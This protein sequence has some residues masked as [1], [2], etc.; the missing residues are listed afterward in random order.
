MKKRFE[1]LDDLI[2]EPKYVVLFTFISLLAV[3][4]I[5][6][7]IA[8]PMIRN[9]VTKSLYDNALKYNKE[10]SERIAKLLSVSIRNGESPESVL[11]RFQYMLL[12]SPQTRSQYI[13]IVDDNDTIIAHPKLKYIGLE[14]PNWRMNNSQGEVSFSTSAREGVSIG[15]TLTKDRGPQ[16]VVF[17]APVFSL[18]WS[19][20]VHSSIELIRMDTDRILRSFGLITIPTLFFIILI[21]TFVARRISTRSEEKLIFSIEALNQQ[22]KLTNLLRMTAANANRTPD[23]TEAVENCLKII[24]EHMCWP[25]GHVYLRSIENDNLL[26]P[27]NIWYLKSKKTHT[28]FVHITMKSELGIGID[29]PGKV[30]KNCEKIWLSD[31]NVISDL[32]R[33]QQL[34]DV[35]YNEAFA[36]PVLVGD[37]CIAVLEFFNDGSN[38]I[39]NSLLEISTNI[40]AQL[41]LV[42]ERKEAE[43]ELRKLM[44]EVDAINKDLEIKVKHRTKELEQAKDEG[45]QAAELAKLGRWIWDPSSDS[46]VSCSRELARLYGMSVTEL[47]STINSYEKFISFV[48]VDDQELYDKVRKKALK[49]KSKYDFEYRFISDDKNY[50]YFRE[51]GEVVVNKDDNTKQLI[52]ITQDITSRKKAEDALR[53]SLRAAEEANKTKTEFLA[54][55]SHELRTPLNAIIGFSD[56]IMGS[57]FGPPIKDQYKDY[58]KDINASGKHLLA[59][60]SDVLDVSKVESGTFDIIEDDMFL[61]DII[62]DCEMMVSGRA[63]EACVNLVFGPMNLIPGLHADPLRVKQIL[64]NLISN[65]IKF[66][67][68]G[69]HIW[70]TGN[71]NEE[72]EITI[73]VKDTGIGISKE[74]FSKVFEKFGQIR[75]GYEHTHEG[76]GLGLTL[77]KSM[78]ECHGGTLEILSNVGVG[79]E[80]IIKFPKERT[81][82]SVVSSLSGVKTA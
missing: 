45:E 68:E 78:V 77:V 54:N 29:L 39:D 33:I 10:Q 7:I 46:Y 56:I 60:I 67:Q 58:A 63:N 75:S 44:E 42:F 1:S 51:I 4:I 36:F 79:T 22:T 61:A 35:K 19:V 71:L 53:I 40:G 52:G 25:I 76:T 5:I 69:G 49:R 31:S 34:N 13:C 17:Q 28:N 15:G 8:T 6:G 37:R 80:I 20:C 14:V 62:Y 38:C 59:I 11:E 16:N 43:V 48:H 2:F 74:D 82:S 18:P 30:M 57:L 3:A 66:T 12:N 23:F 27:S 72:N 55:M 26:I 81:V 65:A 73:A 64:L 24:C 41:G 9:Q 50:K 32:P 21:C 70:V 47:L